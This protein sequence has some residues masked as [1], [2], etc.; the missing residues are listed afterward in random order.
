MR[1]TGPWPR[2]WPGRGNPLPRQV[3]RAGYILKRRG[4]GFAYSRYPSGVFRRK[5]TQKAL[6]AEHHR[7]SSCIGKLRPRRPQNDAAR[8]ICVQAVQKHA[9]HITGSGKN[10]RH[11]QPYICEVSPMR[12][13]SGPAIDLRST[14]TVRFFRAS[15]RF[16][17]HPEPPFF[18]TAVCVRP[19]IAR[20]FKNSRMDSPLNKG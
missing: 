10:G 13:F 12:G 17:E 20:F 3:F 7:K 4:E 8:K 9:P 19:Q 6:P 15:H 11:V 16:A 1:R 5:G 18:R 14:Q 2:D